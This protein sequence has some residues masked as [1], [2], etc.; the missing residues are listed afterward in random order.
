[1]TRPADVAES[2]EAVNALG[3]ECTFW[4]GTQ[5]ETLP[6]MSWAPCLAGVLPGL[7]CE[8][9]EVAGLG[10]EWVQDGVVRPD[11]TQDG[12]PLG[13]IIASRD[14]AYPGKTATRL[15]WLRMSDLG[16]LAELRGDVTK[17]KCLPLV[18][19]L[20]PGRL[21]ANVDRSAD[22]PGGGF[23]GNSGFVTLEGGEGGVTYAASEPFV[24]GSIYTPTTDA[25][26]GRLLDGVTAGM[27]RADGLKPRGTFV[28]TTPFG[29]AFPDNA[30]G[31]DFLIALERDGY[32]GSAIYNPS[33]GFQAL[34]P[35]SPEA[36]SGAFNLSTD[37]KAWVW[38]SNQTRT[39]PFTFV[40]NE[41]YTAP[42]TTS[43][44]VLQQTKRRLT[45]SVGGGSSI[46]WAVGCGH[47]AQRWENTVML[48]RLSDGAFWRVVDEPVLNNFTPYAITCD[49]IYG[50]LDTG[51]LARLRLDKLGEPSPAE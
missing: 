28:D 40:T 2:F 6:K 8:R 34:L 48:V 9:V 11:P 29:S 21:L 15:W 47:A 26:Y 3:C 44:A 13:A 4:L 22:K 17:G 32:P 12:Y 1:V 7:G 14:F 36:D 16:V 19:R 27:Y 45:K 42:Y 38:T 33:V 25:I 43:P 31:H 51:P 5:P 46:P 39:A 37:G 30:I 20:A 24:G 50:H 35:P 18:P 41:V 23:S 49:H 10:E